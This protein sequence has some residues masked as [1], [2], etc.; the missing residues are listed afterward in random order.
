MVL[1]ARATSAA[2]LVLRGRLLA[3][4]VH[5]GLLATRA[6]GLLGADAASL[7]AAA[8]FWDDGSGR[9][10]CGGGLVGVGGV[11]GLD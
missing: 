2:E 10:H 9:R 5:G 1:T 3:V 8:S 6:L 7:A 4:A 11:V